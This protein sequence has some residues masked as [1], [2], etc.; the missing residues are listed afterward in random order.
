MRPIAAIDADFRTLNESRGWIR[1]AGHPNQDIQWFRE[2]AARLSIDYDCV[3]AVVAMGDFWDEIK[4]YLEG[5]HLLV[6]AASVLV[7]CNG[8]PKTCTRKA[9]KTTP[10]CR[11]CQSL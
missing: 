2:A 1:N 4:A 8:V 3:A 11:T 6:A 9:A 7:G 5:Q 10:Y